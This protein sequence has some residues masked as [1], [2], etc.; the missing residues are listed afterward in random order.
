MDIVLHAHSGTSYRCIHLTY[1]IMLMALLDMD[2]FFTIMYNISSKSFNYLSLFGCILFCDEYIY[3][4]RF[5]FLFTSLCCFVTIVT[6]PF[7][8]T[9][10]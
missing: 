2:A 6:S 5:L 3:C 4:L 8:A 10:G 1:I 9:I 7:I